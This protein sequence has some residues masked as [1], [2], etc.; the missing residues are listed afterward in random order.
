[1]SEEQRVCEGCSGTGCIGEHTTWEDRAMGCPHRY[2]CKMC[3]ECD[4][5][6]YRPEHFRGDL[7]GCPCGTCSPDTPTPGVSIDNLGDLSRY[8]KPM[9]YPPTTI[10]EEEERT[11]ASGFGNG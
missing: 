8:V 10:G 9:N 2:G 1:M 11:F 3:E 6:G 5:W 7:C 4:G